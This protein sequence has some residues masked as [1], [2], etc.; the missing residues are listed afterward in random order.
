MLT[1][2][3]VSDDIEAKNNTPT[4]ADTILNQTFEY[5]DPTKPTKI[6]RDN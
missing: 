5:I 3:G 2:F 1:Q 6:W 4:E